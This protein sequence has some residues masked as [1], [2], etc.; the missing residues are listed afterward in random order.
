MKD[1]F[2]LYGIISL[3]ISGI[4]SFFNLFYNDLIL[5]I[6]T[7]VFFG[8]LVIILPFLFWFFSRKHNDLVAS[9]FNNLFQYSLIIFLVTLI[10]RDFYTIIINI[11]L[12]L[13]IVIAL[14]ALAIFFPYEEKESKPLSFWFII[15]I[16]LVGGVLVFFKTRSLG[17]ISYLISVGAVFLVFI[18]SKVFDGDE[19]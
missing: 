4:V 2:I 8:L 3:I 5:T 16:S 14:G 11:N 18:L 10:A 9:I 6:F 1:D 19:K 7:Y 13:I 15:L 12:F 17:W